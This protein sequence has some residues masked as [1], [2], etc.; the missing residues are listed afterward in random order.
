MLEEKLKFM[1]TT[2]AKQI[3]DQAEH[4]NEVDVESNKLSMELN[5]Q[6][7]EQELKQNELNKLDIINT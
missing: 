5:R 2:L 1:T 6:R 4:A 7:E 3:R